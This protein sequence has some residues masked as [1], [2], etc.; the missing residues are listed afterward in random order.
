MRILFLMLVS[1]SSFANTLPVDAPI[2]VCEAKMQ[3]IADAIATGNE[4]AKKSVLE[5]GHCGIV[6]SGFQYRDVTVK[7]KIS[8]ITVPGKQGGYGV[9][10][11][12]TKDLY[13]VH[14][15]KD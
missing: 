1:M 10:Y 7:G 3:A 11:I 15:V 12:M 2:C 8:T 13:S 4:V 9:A 5:S 6:M 14:D